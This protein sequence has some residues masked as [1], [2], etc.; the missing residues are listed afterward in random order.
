MRKIFETNKLLIITRKKVGRRIT[1]KV[2]PCLW[3]PN[4]FECEHKKIRVEGLGWKQWVPARQYCD[5]PNCGKKA[6]NFRSVLARK[7]LSDKEDDRLTA[8]YCQWKMIMRTPIRELVPILVNGFNHK[9]KTQVE[10]LVQL[11]N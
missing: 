10:E 2:I 8:Q 1:P 6:I 5:T 3:C 9:T 7:L 11:V 4:T